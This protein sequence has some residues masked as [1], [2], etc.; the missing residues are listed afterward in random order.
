MGGM[1]GIQQELCLNN[2]Y[3]KPACQLCRLHCPQGCIHGDLQIDLK[4]CDDCGLC[5]S[6]CPAEAIGGAAYSGES[7]DALMKSAESPLFFSCC[8]QDSQSGWPCLG[9]LDARLLLASVYSGPEEDRQVVVDDRACARCKPAVAA[10]VQ[11]LLRDVGEMLRAAGKT[12]L[13]HGEAVGTVKR[14][15]K[16]VSRRSFFTGMIGEA[17]HVV[18]EIA[19]NNTCCEALPR[20]A[21]FARHAG[22]FSLSGPISTKFFFGIAISDACRACGLCTRICP[23]QAITVQDQGQILEFYHLPQN[24]T[25][26]GVCAAHCPQG[27][28][29]LGPAPAL[30]KYHVATRPLPRCIRCGSLYQPVGKQV[31]C[32]ECLWKETCD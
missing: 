21:L 28:L 26:C 27:A 31:L 16:Q 25:G 12:P 2:R 32:L 3:E 23:R 5:L 15:E 9:F 22:P 18:R 6:A 29:S 20:Q 1:V 13:I 14:R 30:A 10:Y 17:L 19:G 7:L 8:R 24:C 4:R 11:E